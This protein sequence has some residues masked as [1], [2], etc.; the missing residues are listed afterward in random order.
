MFKN[1]IKVLHLN[2]VSEEN[3]KTSKK[4]RRGAGVRALRF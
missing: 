1:D 2:F 3:P 4:S